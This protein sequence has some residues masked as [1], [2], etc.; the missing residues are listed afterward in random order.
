[1]QASSKRITYRGGIVIFDIPA[2]WVEE[3]EPDGGG[4]F[5]EDRPDSGTLRLSVLSFDSTDTPASEMART[6]LKGEQELRTDGLPMQYQISTTKEAEEE[7]ELHSWRIAV[8]VEPRSVRI[9][10]FTYTILTGQL[11]QARIAN[12]FRAVLAAVRGAT[13]SK[14]QGARSDA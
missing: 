9:A 1:V 8:P 4:T 3:Y 7:L 13:F 14:A 2:A 12:E 6:A 10:I 5:Y 11:G